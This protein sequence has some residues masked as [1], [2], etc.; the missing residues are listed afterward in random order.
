MF[1]VIDLEVLL[2]SSNTFKDRRLILALRGD[3]QLAKADQILESE[4]EGKIPGT[5]SSLIPGSFSV[6]GRTGSLLEV[7]NLFAGVIRG[8]ERRQ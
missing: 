4:V 5:N 8:R 3:E 2:E 1:T 6:N 7:D